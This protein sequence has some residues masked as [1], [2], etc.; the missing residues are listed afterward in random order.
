MSDLYEFFKSI[1]ILANSMWES[2]LL[3]TKLGTCVAIG[4]HLTISSRSVSTN[5][6]FT[7]EA[8]WTQT[9]MRFHFGWKYH[10]G[11]QSAPYLCSHELRRNEIQ[12]GM[13]FISFKAHVHLKLS[14]G[15]DFISVILKGMKFHFVW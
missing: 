4:Y 11:V 7:W 5:S 3:L 1:T 10:F 15:M 12:N 9:R 2:W 14:V 8:K 6:T 13:Y